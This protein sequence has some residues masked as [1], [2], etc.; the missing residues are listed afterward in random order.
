MSNTCTTTAPAV[1]DGQE[2]LSI[3]DCFDKYRL[4]RGHL[5]RLI[6]SGAVKSV[7]LREKGKLRGRRLVFADSLRS[8]VMSHVED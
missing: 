4:R 6:A 1:H 2:F 5:N 3:T 7:S 8:W